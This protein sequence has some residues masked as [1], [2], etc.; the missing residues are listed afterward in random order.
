MRTNP[1]LASA[2]LFK[3]NKIGKTCVDSPIS[4]SY[5][6]FMYGRTGQRPNDGNKILINHSDETKYIE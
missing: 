5:L 2:N 4:I 6:Q 3:N 1:L